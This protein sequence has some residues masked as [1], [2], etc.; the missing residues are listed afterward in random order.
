[1]SSARARHYLLLF[2]VFAGYVVLG[3]LGVVLG[4]INES[5]G[6]V[7]PPSGFALALVILAGR[8]IWPAILAGA[9]FIHF[10]ES[11]DVL[12]AIPIGAGNAIEAIVGA[13]LVDR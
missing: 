4:T 8:Q 11:A 10:A 9:I 7:W 13:A 2:A 5:P 6:A 3:K 1:M 12:S